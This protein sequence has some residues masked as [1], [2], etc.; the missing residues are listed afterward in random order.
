MHTN[1]KGHVEMESIK[2]R[3]KDC[4]ESPEAGRGKEGFSPRA[5]K[6]STAYLDFKLLVSGTVRLISIV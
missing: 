5:L 2:L 4:P 1:R 3:A 6:G